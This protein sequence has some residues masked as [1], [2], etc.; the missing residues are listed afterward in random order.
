MPS[1]PPCSRFLR[2]LPFL[3]LA[4]LAQSPPEAPVAPAEPDPS[5][6][7][8]LGR[9]LLAIPA[10]ISFGDAQV[11][12]FTPA[13]DLLESTRV[14][15]E[16]SSSLSAASADGQPDILLSVSVDSARLAPDFDDSGCTRWRPCLPEKS[17]DVAFFGHE[18]RAAVLLSDV[19]PRTNVYV[20]VMN[21]DRGRELGGKL[22]PSLSGKLRIGRDSARRPVCG[23]LGEGGSCSGRGEC[24]AGAGG[25]SELGDCYCDGGGLTQPTGR[26]CDKILERPPAPTTRP[27]PV[28]DAP[29]ALTNAATVKV[30]N[31]PGLYMQWVVPA[32]NGKVSVRARVLRGNVVNEEGEVVKV[33]VGGAGTGVFAREGGTPSERDED[34]AKLVINKRGDGETDLYEFLVQGDGEERQEWTVRLAGNLTVGSGEAWYSVS[35]GRCGADGLPECPFSDEEEGGFPTG[36]IIGICVVGGVLILAVVIGVVVRRRMRG[37]VWGSTA[38]SQVGA[39]EQVQVQ[40]NGHGKRAGRLDLEE[41]RRR[42]E[43]RL[44]A[45]TEVSIDMGE[46]SM[47]ASASPVS[48]SAGGSA[49]TGNR[50]GGTLP[51]DSSRGGH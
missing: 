30:P 49:E 2:L 16:F 12:T 47:S 29:P 3:F 35:V 11:F 42:K 50:R 32:G 17:D 45:A 51:T 24:A 41:Y 31:G 21:V 5:A 20:S 7:I 22:T 10:T 15:V 23:G 19:G 40:G 43:A 39:W 14:L 1:P 33:G 18:T 37:R 4:A 36:V 9:D 28:P 48:T 26:F 38:G 27:S 13:R 6:P 46:D 8:E 25:E 44:Q 34:V